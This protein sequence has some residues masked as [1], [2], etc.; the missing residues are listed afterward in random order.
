MIFKEIK[1]W[2]VGMPKC[3]RG[4]HCNYDGVIYKRVRFGKGLSL[5]DSHK[6]TNRYCTKC[7]TD[8]TKHV[9]SY[10]GG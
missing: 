5:N 1:N 8:I 3:Q 10:V 2:M 7:M 4:S 6:V 9:N